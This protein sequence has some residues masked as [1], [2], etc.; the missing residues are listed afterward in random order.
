MN[1]CPV[2]L[3]ATDDLAKVAKGCLVAAGPETPSLLRPLVEATA[4]AT[5]DGL[6]ETRFP[7]L[8][9]CRSAHATQLEY[10]AIGPSITF[11]LAGTCRITPGRDEV[12]MLPGE[13]LVGPLM[14]AALARIEPPEAGEPFLSLILRLDREAVGDVFA[15]VTSEHSAP[16]RDLPAN[17]VG[18]LTEPMMRSLTGLT[19]LTGLTEASASPD[20][21]TV[22]GAPAEREL[23]YRLFFS[24][25]AGRL[26]TFLRDTHPDRPVMRAVTWLAQN[27]SAD[28]SVEQL[29]ARVALSPSALYRQ[30][31]ELVGLSPVQYRNRLRLNTARQ[32][33]IVEDMSTSSAA[34]A[35]G[36]RTVSQFS[37]DYR[38]CYGVPPYRH[39]R[40]AA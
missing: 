16:V 15:Q 39:A 8:A 7:R 13:F 5:A 29:A 10:A 21:A 30:F 14:T 6:T 9:V 22:P 26:R 35:V 24:D 40:Q 34:R 28:I 2:Y 33:M 38:R 1:D 27:V 20:D 37:R 25:Q 23:L 12:P 17:P 31:R 11:V 36:Y 18:T 19:G 4:A 32:L 3:A